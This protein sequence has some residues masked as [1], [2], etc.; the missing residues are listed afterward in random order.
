MS[1]IGL[2]SQKGG[3]G[4]TTSAIALACALAQRHSVH[5]IDADPQGSA[6][7]WASIA[8]LPKGLTVDSV[9]RVSELK[10]RQPTADFTIVDTKG[11]LS[12]DVLPLL[13]LALIPCAPSLFDLWS[14]EP[15]IELVKAQQKARKG[16]R[17]AVY[18]TKVREGTVL[19]A[20]VLEEIESFGLP[21]LPVHLC[22]RVGYPASIAAGSNPVRYKTTRLEALRFAKSVEE[23]LK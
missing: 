20:D 9:S 19:G 3:A 1:T 22:D 16:L 18:A 12:A 11:E 8:E 5:L 14:A 21:V 10:R 23:L 17:A 13:D 6:V 15:T 7:R 4:K 2:V